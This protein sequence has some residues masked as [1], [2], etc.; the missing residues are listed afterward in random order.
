MTTPCISA[1]EGWNTLKTQ[2]N[3]HEMRIV[4]EDL[5]DAAFLHYNHGSWIS[6]GDPRLIGVAL[7]QLPSR[8]ESA[9]CD[10]F[11]DHLSLADKG[12][13]LAHR[14]FSLVR[15]ARAV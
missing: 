13:D 12:H 4:C 11:E 2:T 7:A 9:L 14:A 15:I 10:P 5:G 1:S 6:E 8:A 3:V